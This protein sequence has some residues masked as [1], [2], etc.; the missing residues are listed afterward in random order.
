MDLLY[1]VIFSR[2]RLWLHLLSFDSPDGTG[3]HEY[4]FEIGKE[5]LELDGKKYNNCEIRG[6]RARTAVDH[7]PWYTTNNKI[8]F[9]QNGRY[10]WSPNYVGD[11]DK[12]HK[13][14]ISPDFGY[15]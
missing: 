4:N 12:F 15:V 13:R 10:Y 2:N 6:Y 5:G 3:D 8:I 1:K 11:M 14:V 7:R 9:S